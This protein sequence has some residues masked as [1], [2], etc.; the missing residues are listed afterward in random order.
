MYLKNIEITNF[1][2]YNSLNLDF[3]K[4]NLLESIYVL[5]LTKS[6][7]SI[8][9][10]SLIK[11]DKLNSIIKGKIK[12]RNLP[13]NLE[14]NINKTNKT[15]KMDNKKIVKSSDY[16]SKGNIIIFYPDDLNL[17][18][19]SPNERRRFLNIEISQLNSN[20]L[21]MYNDFKKILKIRNDLLKKIANNERYDKNYFEIVTDFFINKSISIYKMRKKFIDKLNE[22]C[23]NIYENI[24]KLINFK[25]NYKTNIDLKDNIEN[26]Y[27]IMKEK[28]N[29]C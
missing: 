6:H 4:T 8:I 26:I 10:N 29:D 2:N 7:R 5:C 25:I 28:L 20:Y 3:N 9:D 12:N 23:S 19:G 21:I 1:R 14:I 22:N 24:S 16:I 15:L 17:V 27:N 13:I 18:K 11:N